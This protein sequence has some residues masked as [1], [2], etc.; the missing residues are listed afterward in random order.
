MK[1]ALPL[2][3]S[4][5][6]IERRFGVGTSVYFIFKQFIMFANIVFVL[7]GISPMGNY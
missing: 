1:E 5:A 6:E 4:L 2:S 7:L 3:I